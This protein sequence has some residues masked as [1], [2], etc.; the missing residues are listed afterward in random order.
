MTYAW[1]NPDGMWLK[2]SMTKGIT[3][4]IITVSLTHHLN[5]AA[6]LVELPKEAL[7]MHLTPVPACVLRKVILGETK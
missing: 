2:V 5:K 3:E 7:G 6:V 1:I 4:D